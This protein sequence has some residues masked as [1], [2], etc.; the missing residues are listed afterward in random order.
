MFCEIV[1]IIFGEQ[2]IN[3]NLHNEDGKEVLKNLLMKSSKANFG[4]IY[5]HN[6][7]LI[8]TNIF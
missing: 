7:N 2:K 5:L 1:K 6:L 3:I 4:K 8:G